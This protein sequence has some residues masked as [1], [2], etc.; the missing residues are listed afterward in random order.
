MRKNSLTQRLNI[1]KGQVEALSTIIDEGKSCKK[2]I[3]QFHAVNSGLKRVIEL[4][5]QENLTSCLQ[6]TTTKDREEIN[7]I[8]GEFL[9][10]T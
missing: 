7:L 8:L 6:S 4:Y 3:E 9:K 1:I 2:A 10:I 5:L